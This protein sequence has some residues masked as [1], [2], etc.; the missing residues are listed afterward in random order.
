MVSDEGGYAY[1]AD[2]W[3]DGRGALYHDIWISRPQGIFLIY[4]AVI[5]WFGGS[6]TDLRLIAWA[7]NVLTMIA[8]WKIASRWRGPQVAAGATM[9]FGLLMGSPAI[10]GFTANAEIFMALPAALSILTLMRACNRSWS[11][12]WL[13]ISGVL[14]G[15]ATQLKPSGIVMIAVAGLF[16]ALMA[17]DSERF[18]RTFTFRIGAMAAG[19]GISMLPAIYH[20]YRVGWDAFVY[21]SVT[22]RLT[23]QSTPTGSLAHHVQALGE[24]SA[25]IWPV[26]VAAA[27]IVTTRYLTAPIQAGT[28]RAPSGR[29][30]LQPAGSVGIVSASQVS[31][32][33]SDPMRLLVQIW[34]VGCLFGIS[35][36]GDWWFHYL[37][38]IAAPLAIWLAVSLADLRARLSRV[39]HLGLAIMVALMLLVPYGVLAGDSRTEMT[40]ELFGHPGYADQ[41]A[42]ADYIA[43]RT[44]PGTTI[45]VA[46]DQAALYY[47]A[48]R[49]S[50]YCYLY[51][52]ELRAFPDSQRDLIAMVESSE[53]PYYIIGTRQLAPFNDRGLAF[54]ESVQRH[55]VLETVVRGVPIYRARAELP[56]PLIP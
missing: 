4:G 41:E 28:Q 7:C 25:R 14:I 49:T 42:V 29:I 16:I 15:I 37:I 32:M 35:I 17:W 21:A 38:Q 9:M 3:F 33:T 26:Y 44:R 10:E 52:Q 46:F 22:Y 30:R 47:L 54:W 27:L 56:S 34:I 18:V 45:F 50:T 31:A 51:D 6:T 20:G 36:G 23:R 48:D 53:R 5:E 24:L 12:A 40:T 2:R 39:R 11:P 8:V 55:Y 19:F 13:M 1:A 43:E